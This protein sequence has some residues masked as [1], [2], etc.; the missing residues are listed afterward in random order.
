MTKSKKD[1]D[2]DQDLRGLSEPTS[3]IIHPQ[4]HPAILA[5]YTN[6]PNAICHLCYI[7]ICLLRGKI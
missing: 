4:M 2:D 3:I 5:N 1:P 6:H 7:V